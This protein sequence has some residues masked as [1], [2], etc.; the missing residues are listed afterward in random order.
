MV[1]VL[2]CLAVVAVVAVF[3]L[4]FSD[5]VDSLLTGPVIETGRWSS[6]QMGHV[7]GR[8]CRRLAGHG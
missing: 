6:T 3:G 7:M 8:E 5:R 2:F 1:A 4:M